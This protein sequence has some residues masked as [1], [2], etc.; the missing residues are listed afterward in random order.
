MAIWIIV[1]ATKGIGLEFVKQL[2]E[3]GD[4]VL[5]TARTVTTASNLWQLAGGTYAGACR[6]LQCDVT[7]DDSITV[8]HLEN[9]KCL[10][11]SNR[12]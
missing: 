5:A 6:I 8:G 1:G 7:K 3:R 2:L 11:R 4:H 9:P 12:C 10:T